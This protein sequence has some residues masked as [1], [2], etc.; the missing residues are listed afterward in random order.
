MPRLALIPGDGI[1][2]EVSV[3]VVRLLQAL[4]GEGHSLDWNV[5]D[6]S[7]ERYLRTGK[8]LPDGGM[9]ELAGYD[10]IFAGAF[11]DP[12]VPDMAHA[13]ALLLG[14]RFGLDLYVNLRPVRALSDA[15]VPLKGRCAGDVDILIVRENTEGAYVNVGGLFKAGTP[16]KTAVQEAIA[17]RRGVDRILRYA[18]EQ[19]SSRPRGRLVMADKHNALTFVSGLWYRMFQEVRRDYPSVESHHIFV[20][21]LCHDLIRDPGRFD[22]IV[23]SNLFGDLLS[24]L[25]AALA[26]GLGVAPSANLNPR[27]RKGLFEPVHG[28]AHDIAGRGEANPLAA[29]LSAAMMLDF[30]GMSGA[31]RRV[32]RAVRDCVR[33]G[34]VTRDLGGRLGTA[35]AGEAVLRRL[36]E[37]S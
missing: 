23:T 2:A 3:E 8:A 36:S 21:A 29:L 16:D 11:G 20:D 27:T 22:V 28:S 1:G 14:A 19:A 34:E 13:R 35:G 10:A 15:V 9:A 6:C 32:E 5:Y 37:G 12:R 31:A 26:G 25:A 7:A 18:F 4:K 30:I 17:T 33:A 24:D